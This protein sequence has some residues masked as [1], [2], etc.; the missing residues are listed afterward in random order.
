MR[1]GGG[2]QRKGKGKIMQV[3]D[4]GQRACKLLVRERLR[5]ESIH[6]RGH[7]LFNDRDVRTST[8][9]QN[10]DGRG[11]LVLGFVCSNRLGCLDAA[12]D[13]HLNVHE[14]G[15]GVRRRRRRRVVVLV[16]RW[17]VAYDVVQRFFAVGGDMDFV[18]VLAQ[19]QCADFTNRR[20][21]VHHQ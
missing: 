13:R 2:F 5:E 12:H 4:S 16:R 17:A 11:H 14:N 1:E 19:D 21:I 3:S 10:R 18:A 6:S 20:R 15:V 8:H 9:T 7:G